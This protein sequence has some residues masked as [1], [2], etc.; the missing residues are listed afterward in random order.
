MAAGDTAAAGEPVECAGSFM[1]I[2]P[3]PG[4]HS[5]SVTR[6]GAAGATCSHRPTAHSG[7]RGRQPSTL[8]HY[9]GKKAQTSGLTETGYI[10]TTPSLHYS[11]TPSRQFLNPEPRT[12]TIIHQPSSII[13][14]PAIV[15]VSHPLLPASLLSARPG[16]RS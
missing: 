14:S 4:A 15:Q 13:H 8:F 3:A 7:R 9:S 1:R 11:T 5:A 2:L 6:F 16:Q 10:V 12:L